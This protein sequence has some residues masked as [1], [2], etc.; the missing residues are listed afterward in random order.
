MK[1]GQ[2]LLVEPLS[3]LKD[4]CR[5]IIVT[6]DNNVDIGMIPGRIVDHRITGRQ[7][8]CL[9]RTSDEEQF[10]RLQDHSNVRTVDVRRPS[11]EDIFVAY[12]HAA[13]LPADSRV[14]LSQEV[15]R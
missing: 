7:C 4:N 3:E 9:I 15:S 13:T 5:E 1:K 14:N 11:L 8:V 10:Y 6:F 12:M 2:L